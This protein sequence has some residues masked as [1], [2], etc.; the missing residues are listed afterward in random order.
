VTKDEIAKLLSRLVDTYL[1]PQC[2]EYD[3]IGFTEVV[4]ILDREINGGEG[5]G[6]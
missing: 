1:E 3:S 5:T 4:N 6:N 2:I